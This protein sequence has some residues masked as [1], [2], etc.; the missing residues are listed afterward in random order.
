MKSGPGRKLTP[1]ETEEIAMNEAPKIVHRAH[2][3]MP[4]VFGDTS[5]TPCTSAFANMP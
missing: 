5:R 1:E 2:G 4:C 3:F